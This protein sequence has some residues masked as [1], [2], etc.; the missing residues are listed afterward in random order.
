MADIRSKGWWGILEL[1]L[2]TVLATTLPVQ[3]E[4]GGATAP[5]P[6]KEVVDETPATFSERTTQP[7]LATYYARRYNG[8][9][10]ASGIRYNP[11]K[12]TA[13]HQSLP[14]GTRVRVVNLA[15]GREIVVKV[16]DRCRPRKIPFIDLSRAAAR[17]LGFLGKGVARVMIIPLADPA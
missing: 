4:E 3:A 7:G 5:E 15:N 13:A 9:R 11:E 10:T 2:L 17:S 6:K 16:I 12:L 1:S 8:R 14:L